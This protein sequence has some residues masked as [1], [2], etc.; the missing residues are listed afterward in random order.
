MAIAK[1]RTTAKRR[2][3]SAAKKRKAKVG[4]QAATLKL[5]GRTYKKSM[6]GLTKP[7]ATAKAKAR[8]A[9]GKGAAIKKGVK[10]YCL[11]T[12]G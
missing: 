1:K 2:K 7:E 3:P 9:A 8:R 5:F 6:C 11:Y 10:G 4:E 12:R